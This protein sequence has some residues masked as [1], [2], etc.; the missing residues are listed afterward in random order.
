MKV[1]IVDVNV[2]FRN[3]VQFTVEFTS[4]L[5]VET[6]ILEYKCTDLH[7]K[8]VFSTLRQGLRNRIYD[9]SYYY[10]FVGKTFDIDDFATTHTKAY[11]VSSAE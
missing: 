3:T 10:R 8:D 11:A 7:D 2:T 9:E 4:T 5:G 1:R 6:H